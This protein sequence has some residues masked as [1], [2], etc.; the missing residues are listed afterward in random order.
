[1]VIASDIILK[2]EI[3]K[4]A[5]DGFSSF[6]KQRTHYDIFLISTAIGVVYDRQE[7]ATD[8]G[9]DLDISIPRNVFNNRSEPFDKLVQTALLTSNT[10]DMTDEER[11]KLAFSGE[12]D[13]FDRLGFLMKFA[14][15]GIQKLSSLKGID[16]T[17]TME[18]IKTFV[19][20]TAEG[21]NYEIE[22]IKQES[23]AEAIM[24]YD[25]DQ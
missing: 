12:K 7:E 6:F 3:W 9:S 22:A 13:D 14:N 11:L 25:A 10:I 5:A 24:E 21:T 8:D 1:M 17:E 2:G 15:Y 19:I 18:N 23:I 4:Q 16:D 20:G